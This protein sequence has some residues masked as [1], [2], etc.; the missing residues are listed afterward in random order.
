MIILN[1]S[2][3]NALEYNNKRGVVA[4]KNGIFSF[5]NAESRATSIYNADQSVINFNTWKVSVNAKDYGSVANTS[6]PCGCSNHDS[7]GDFIFDGNNSSNIFNNKV[8]LT[9]IVLRN[10]KN[11]YSIDA[12]KNFIFNSSN[13]TMLD[14]SNSAIPLQSIFRYVVNSYQMF[15]NCNNYNGIPWLPYTNI[16]TGTSIE[17]IKDTNIPTWCYCQS[18]YRNCQNINN[19]VQ[20]II[21]N[22]NY[23]MTRTFMNSRPVNL[24]LENC[25]IRHVENYIGYINSNGTWI[26]SQISNFNIIAPATS[27]YYIKGNVNWE[28]PHRFT[29]PTEW[30]MS[31]NLSNNEIAISY[32][33]CIRMFSNKRLHLIENSR[34]RPRAMDNGCFNI[35]NYNN[36]NMSQ[37]GAFTRYFADA[38]IWTNNNAY[39]E[40]FY[41][42]NATG[43]SE[44]TDLNY[45]SWC[46][47]GT[48]TFRNMTLYHPNGVVSNANN[49]VWFDSV[50]NVNNDMNIWNYRGNVTYYALLYRTFENGRFGVR[51]L[52]VNYT[53]RLNRNTFTNLD[54]LEN[55]VIY[56]NYNNNININEAWRE[57]SAFSAQRINNCTIIIGQLNNVFGV[58][59]SA[60]SIQPFNNTIINNS[61]LYFYQCKAQDNGWCIYANCLSFKGW[62]NTLAY[63]VLNNTCDIHNLSHDTTFYGNEKTIYF[64]SNNSTDNAF[65]NCRNLFTNCNFEKQYIR[66]YCPLNNMGLF[67]NCNYNN[68]YINISCINANNS[69]LYS[70]L[71]A[72]MYSRHALQFFNTRFENTYFNFHR[73]TAY[74][75]NYQFY[76]DGLNNLGTGENTYFNNCN[77]DF[78][79]ESSDSSV[80]GTGRLIM[81]GFGYGKTLLGIGYFN[82]GTNWAIINWRNMSLNV[83]NAVN[84]IPTQYVAQIGP[85]TYEETSGNVNLYYAFANSP[86][87]VFDSASLYSSTSSQY[88]A[89]DN[90]AKSNGLQKVITPNLDF[91]F[92][93]VL[94]TVLTTYNYETVNSWNQTYLVANLRNQ[95]SSQLRNTFTQYNMIWRA[96]GSK[97]IIKHNSSSWNYKQIAGDSSLG[98]T[99]LNC[100]FFGSKGNQ[101]YCEISSRPLV[102]TNSSLK[103]VI[104]VY[105]TSSFVNRNLNYLDYVL[106]ATYDTVPNISACYGNYI[107]LGR[108]MVT[109]MTKLYVNGIQEYIKNYATVVKT[110]DGIRVE[111]MANQQ[112]FDWLNNNLN[113]N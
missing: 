39:I 66:I 50:F 34:L 85:K 36:G 95:I 111:C 104:S 78:E 75:T 14:S 28:I 37:N 20:I 113:S 24:F 44:L 55:C 21:N 58:D 97:I 6:F 87:W 12:D 109:I 103:G 98:T 93:N 23:N 25:I 71:Q 96:T 65:K 73:Y 92:E 48:E 72:G 5:A 41:S 57:V 35:Y 64:S 107:R 17:Y 76:G 47:M 1:N 22:V 60:S 8:N 18:M 10:F 83:N 82:I 52:K 54:C 31:V 56:H 105:T 30:G 16:N 46:M 106:Y 19:S 108:K 100:N 94:P 2:N 101:V 67:T 61:S 84:W 63:I 33:N 80:I 27:H 4:I 45:N 29:L 86:V 69:Y 49:P 90:M 74:K 99:Q 110:S 32:L 40:K 112:Y 9:S 102:T 89:Y 11:C 62:Y 91:F 68:G 3:I 42:T 51:N 43:E 53:D 88:N 70:G 79:E 26:P 7:C 81:D 13:Y 77:F 38:Y 59:F 15:M